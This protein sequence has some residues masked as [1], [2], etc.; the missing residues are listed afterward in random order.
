MCFLVGK[1]SSSTEKDIK[2]EKLASLVAKAYCN[3]LRLR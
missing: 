3:D 2:I 1:K